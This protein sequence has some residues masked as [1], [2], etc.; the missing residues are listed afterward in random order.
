[1]SFD[2]LMRA[3][4]YARNSAELVAS[5]AF[6]TS[7]PVTYQPTQ[8]CLS[9][10]RVNGCQTYGECLFTGTDDDDLV[11]TERFVFSKNDKKLGQKLFKTITGI[12]TANFVGGHM[13]VQGALRSGEKLDVRRSAGTVYGRV[14]A[15]DPKESVRIAG[16][17][18]DQ[19][20]KFMC[21]KEDSSLLKGDFLTD[22]GITYRL[23]ASLQPMYHGTGIHHYESIVTRLES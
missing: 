2:G 11:I 7:I 8:A 19:P 13:R 5:T 17:G 12:T 6:S 18:Q 14:Y 16:A 4:P 21:R 20:L 10:I 9:Q 22:G 23:E 3:I 15:P 1:M